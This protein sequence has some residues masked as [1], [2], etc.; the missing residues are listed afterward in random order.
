MEVP[1]SPPLPSAC[2]TF[3]CNTVLLPA[4]YMHAK[5]SLGM[6]ADQQN[7]VVPRFCCVGV[8]HIILFFVLLYSFCTSQHVCTGQF[9][10]PALL[11]QCCVVL[12]TV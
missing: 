4:Y 2:L 5:E 9:S 3:T 6:V 1:P 11:S 7:D 12:C 8:L 10:F